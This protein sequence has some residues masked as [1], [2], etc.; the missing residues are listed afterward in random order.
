MD[1]GKLLYGASSSCV[2]Q[3]N[4]PCDEHNESISDKKVTKLVFHP[5][6]TDEMVHRERSMNHEIHKI[7]GHQDWTII[8]DISCKAKPRHILSTYDPEGIHKCFDKLPSQTD[9]GDIDSYS[10]MM[11]GDYGGD[12]LESYFEQNK[13]KLHIRPV[14]LSMMEKMKSLFKGLVEMNNH[15]IIHDDIKPLNI[16]LHKGV[17][18]YIDY[19]LSAKLTDTE[20]FINRSRS[21]FKGSRIYIHYPL[22]YLLYHRSNEEL[23]GEYVNILENTYRGGYTEPY[24]S[25]LDLYQDLTP[26][27]T[28]ETQFK[29]I[30]LQ[31]DSEEDILR[32]IDVYGLGMCIPYLT[33]ILMDDEQYSVYIERPIVRDF[34]NLFNKMID[35]YIETRISP[36]EANNEFNQLLSNYKKSKRSKK[37]KKRSKKKKKGSKKKR[38]K[39]K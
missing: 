6:K 10:Q 5:K 9:Y 35:P 7:K 14:F 31:M 29:N 37:K 1:G 38:S 15:D 13:N 11:N 4:I 16:V 8:Y 12:T 23:D 25:D 18:K 30:T 26:E 28:F 34:M 36:D 20:F 2:F 3:P 32:G 21:E 19:G 39:K 33:R 24:R 27:D 17:F 22:D